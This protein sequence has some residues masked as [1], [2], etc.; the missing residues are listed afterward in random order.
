MDPDTAKS[1]TGFFQD[2][3]KFFL[4]GVG[5]LLPTLLTIAILIWAYQLVDAYI[6]QYITEGFIAGLA[7]TAGAPTSGTVDR[8]RD[9]L[10]YGVRTGQLDSKGRWVTNEYLIVH[11][12]AHRPE[13][14]DRPYGSLAYRTALWRIA[15]A[16]YKLGL[17]GFLLAIALVYFVGFFVASFIGRTA[18]GLLERVQQRVPLVNA[19]YPHV[20]QIT[21]FLLSENRL[22]FRSVVAVEYP[23]RGMWSLG[24]LTGEGI[25]RLSEATTEKDLVSVFIP[26]SPTPVTGYVITVPRSDV[27]ELPLSI[28]EALRFTISGGV[29]KPET[30]PM[31]GAPEGPEGVTMA[32]FRTRPLAQADSGVSNADPSSSEAT[33][34]SPR[35]GQDSDRGRAS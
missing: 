4:R 7:R 5:A 15:F 32:S 27:I 22:A 3:K 19:V 35:S 23:R 17:V 9:T 1:N 33:D 12:P 25:R 2:F 6:G 18:W 26:S 21:D 31:A 14:P 30:R 29:I 24:L 20:K 34:R 13:R 11:H 8:D 28:D 10:K 16:K